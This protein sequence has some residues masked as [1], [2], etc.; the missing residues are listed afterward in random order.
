MRLEGVPL[1]YCLTEK[2]RGR[3]LLSEL[4]MLM[5][6]KYMIAMLNRKLRVKLM[7]TYTAGPVHPALIWVIKFLSN[8]TRLINSAEHSTQTPVRSSARPETAS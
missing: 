7:Q 3:S 5:T 4:T 8:K 2:S 1:S 6:M